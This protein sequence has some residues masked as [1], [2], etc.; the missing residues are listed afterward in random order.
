MSDLLIRK[1]TKVFLA[2]A[3][4][5]QIQLIDDKIDLSNGCVSWDAVM[6]HMLSTIW[7][8]LFTSVT[9]EVLET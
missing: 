2:G 7:V 8:Q 5:Q 9:Q 6:G 3:I 1:R 4:D